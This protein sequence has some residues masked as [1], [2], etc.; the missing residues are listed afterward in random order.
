MTAL[1][2]AGLWLSAGAAPTGYTIVDLG[3]AQ[4]PSAIDDSGSVAGCGQVQDVCYYPEIYQGGTWVPLER[5]GGPAGASAID[6]AGAVVGE[7][8]KQGPVRWKG[9]H[10]L[11]L[12][13]PPRA[14]P[15]TAPSSAGRPSART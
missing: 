4:L 5:H 2:L 3:L 13:A 10:E 6:R 8:G 1:V 12:T 11:R 9:G 14:S 7:D 15:T